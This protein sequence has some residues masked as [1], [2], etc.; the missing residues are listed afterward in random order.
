M[1][2][3]S[4]VFLLLFLPVM[5]G[6][7]TLTPRRMRPRAICFF[8]LAFYALA[9]LG[10]PASILFLLLCA[11]FTYCATFAVFSVRKRYVVIFVI[12]VLVGV[13]AVLRYLG[14]W[15]DETA[16]RRYIPLGASF[17]LLASFS[18]IMDVRRGD[19]PMPR[20]FIDVLTYITFFP[21][22]I[23][24]PVIKYKNFEQLIKPENMHFS[25]AAVGSG[26]IL[27]ARG[28]IKRVAIA[29]ILDE[30]Y[31]SI[32]EGLIHYTEEPFSLAVVIMLAI[33]LLISV[34][35]AFS[36][37][38]DMGRGIA[39]MLGIQLAPDFGVCLL[40]FTPNAYSRNFLSSLGAWITDYI[41][42]PL[43]KL[44][45][46]EKRT[47]KDARILNAVIS[48]VCA[49]AMLLWFKIGISVLPAIAILLIPSLLN[50]LFDIDR[51]FEEKKY[52]RPIG[53]VVTFPFIT[54]FWMLIK[55]RDLSM[56]E[57]IFGNITLFEPL[58]SYLINQTLSNLELPLVF[59][60]IIIVQLPVI[61]GLLS[62]RRQSPF[63]K[64][65]EFRWCWSLLILFIFVLCIY[66]YLPQYPSLATE[67]FRDIIF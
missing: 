20:N 36:G 46:L 38:S 51:L 19:A 22:M 25:A 16:A 55:T 62:R 61:F 30:S 26:I 17:Y 63:I 52:L 7:Y 12:T 45:G 44:L 15:A 58:Q 56:L 11:I 42:L 57:I 5:L 54:L 32:V 41:R 28:F 39:A 37:Y 65:G 34:Y 40:A 2:F 23:A 24:G 47:G 50:G 33:L 1:L 59:A 3:T 53:T 43:A 21:V 14:V 4:P 29:A 8:S 67:P 48:V 9:N 64:R 18:C 35:F 31:N 10:S 66:Y 49:L 6:V 13:L 60:L 27:F